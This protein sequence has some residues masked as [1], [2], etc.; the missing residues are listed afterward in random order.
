MKTRTAFAVASAVAAAAVFASDEPRFD[1]GRNL[2]ERPNKEL[3]V[4]DNLEWLRAGKIPAHAVHNV[5]KWL[6]LMGE[7]VAAY[8]TKHGYRE[9]P[10]GEPLLKRG[11]FSL[12][13]ML[14]ISRHKVPTMATLKTI[15]DNLAAAGFNELQLY[16]ENTFAYRGWELAWKDWSPMTPEEV[17][18]LDA[19]AWAKGVRLVPNQNSFGHLEKWF[20]HDEYKYLA[21]TPNG[22]RL[23][24]PKVS[25]DSGAALCAT[26][27]KTYEF[28][29]GLFDQLLPCFAHADSIH[30]GCDEVWDIFDEHA[31]SRWKAVRYGVHAVYMDHLLKVNELV[32]ARGS[33]MMFWADMV[34]W[35]YGSLDRIP[36]NAIAVNWG[37]G[38]EKYARGYTCEVEGRA[39]ALRRRGV[40]MVVAPSTKTYEGVCN[41]LEDA[42]GNIGLMSDVA[43]RYNGRGLLLTEWGDGG[44]PCPHLANLPAIVYTGRIC[45]GEPVDEE[46]LAAAIDR[47]AGAKVGAG[48]LALGRTRDSGRRSKINIAAAKAA[49]ARMETDKAPGWVRNGVATLRLLVDVEES[50]QQSRP[51]P[52]AAREYRRLWLEANRPGGLERSCAERR[53]E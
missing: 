12:G 44:H 18:E 27:P 16:T 49:F 25:R 6:E 2:V 34:F 5:I 31:R 4:A 24:R 28:L 8:R 9:L 41:C 1:H 35:D 38:S 17:R 32:N 43:R 13:Y 39:L 10:L 19:Y 33:R 51:C 47:I 37:Y 45:R 40:E 22:Y 14:D 36:K 23:T 48:L 30:V 7:D 29:G 42:F 3:V 26:D 46:A 52:E 11:G 53:F 20:V 15:V 50:K 21:E